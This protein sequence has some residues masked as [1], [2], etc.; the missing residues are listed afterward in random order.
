MVARRLESSVIHV[1]GKSANAREGAA[2]FRGKRALIF[3]D[4]VS[5]GLLEI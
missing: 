4:H 2:A 3:P 5:S 1:H